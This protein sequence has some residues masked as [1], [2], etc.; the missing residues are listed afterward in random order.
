[1]Y[2][3]VTLKYKCDPYFKTQE[4]R[5]SYR[6]LPNNSVILASTSLSIFA[7]IIAERL[8][9]GLCATLLTLD[10]VDTFTSLFTDNFIFEFSV[11][12]LSVDAAGVVTS[13]SIMFYPEI[14]SLFEIPLPQLYS[15]TDDSPQRAILI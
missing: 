5:M 10:T 2:I 6:E 11:T 1:M 12:L 15:G 7:S 14:I 8:S 3:G 9:F 4:K 13:F